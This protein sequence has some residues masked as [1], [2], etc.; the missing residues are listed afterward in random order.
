MQEKIEN[1]EKVLADLKEKLGEIEKQETALS[2]ENID[3][4]HKLEKYEDVVKTNQ[5]KMKHWKKQ[6]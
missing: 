6:V 5:V 4:Q 1:H 3:L 2:K